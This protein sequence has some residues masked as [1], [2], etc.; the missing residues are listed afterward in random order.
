MWARSSSVLPVGARAE[1][2]HVVGV[3]GVVEVV[4]FAH[5]VVR[6]PFHIFAGHLSLFLQGLPGI[7]CPCVVRGYGEDAGGEG[8][9]FSI[10]TKCFRVTKAPTITTANT[11]YFINPQRL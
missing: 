7:K 1:T 3:L 4:G 8:G 9:H 6:D 5:H 2:L 11:R 10:C